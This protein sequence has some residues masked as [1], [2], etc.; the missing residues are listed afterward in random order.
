MLAQFHAPAEAFSDTESLI[1][2]LACKFEADAVERRV[3]GDVDA[4]TGRK[5]GY[6]AAKVARFKACAGGGVGAAPPPSQC[7]GRPVEWIGTCF[8]CMGSHIQATGCPDRWTAAM[9][10]GK[11]SA[12]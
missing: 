8:P 1:V 2:E 3:V 6:D 5:L 12:I 4:E 7:Q 9:C 11:W 10:P